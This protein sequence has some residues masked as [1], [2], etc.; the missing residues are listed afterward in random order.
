MYIG[1]Q[2][3]STTD[4]DHRENARRARVC[5]R[6]KKNLRHHQH[7]LYF[8]RSSALLAKH[9][10]WLLFH[11]LPPRCL[12]WARSK[13]SNEQN[14]SDKMPQTDKITLAQRFRARPVAVRQNNVVFSGEGFFFEI[15]VC[16]GPTCLICLQPEPI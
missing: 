10:V 9:P 15:V 14:N 16:R 13:R 5:P 4:L 3:P 2:C 6:L 12:P 1:Q 8:I 11:H 7:V